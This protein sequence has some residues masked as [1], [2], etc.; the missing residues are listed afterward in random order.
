M[1]VVTRRDKTATTTL[2]TC[3]VG[4]VAVT[5]LLC[6]DIFNCSTMTTTTTKTKRKMVKVT[7]TVAVIEAEMAVVRRST[8]QW[9]VGQRG[10][11]TGGV[12]GRSLPPRRLLAKKS[13]RQADQK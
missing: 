12:R 4:T 11:S 7:E 8:S 9:V 10:G 6:A 2:L 5:T 3:F 1:R 13:R